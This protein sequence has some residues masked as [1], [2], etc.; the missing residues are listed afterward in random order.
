MKKR[1]S[2]VSNLPE[3]FDLAK[4]E[5]AES[6]DAIG[7]YEQLII[8][9]ELIRV[10]LMGTR[11]ENIFSG[12][13]AIPKHEAKKLTTLIHTMPILNISVEDI[14]NIFSKN[15]MLYELKTHNPRYSFGVRQTTVYEH[16][17]TERFIEKE[18]RIFTRNFF[19]QFYGEDNKSEKQLTYVD[20]ID[21][22]IDAI[23]EDF[24][25]DINIR[26]NTLLPDKILIE[27]FE[28]L[29]SNVRVTQM[30]SE[31]KGDNVRKPD[32]SKWI[33]YGVLPY[34]DLKIWK[35]ETGKKLTKQEIAYA[36]SPYG[37][38]GEDL[39]RRTTEETAEIL[40]SVKYLETLAA[41]AA[42]EIPERNKT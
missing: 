7:W 22:P 18:K 32:F 24:R 5:T 30:H 2:H 27:Q 31:L 11:I 36:I 37:D 17:A 13:L 4:Y 39:F 19:A 9:R 3:W 38:R 16:Y 42:S 14:Q 26:V 20:W 41:Y 15:S 34:L 29:L 35:L 23:V 10:L 1:I 25:Y 40:I 6:L 33:L 8:R 28:R 21:E 12:N